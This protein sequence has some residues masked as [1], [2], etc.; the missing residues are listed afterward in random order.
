MAP[1]KLADNCSGYRFTYI[2]SASA[3]SINLLV[4]KT[5]KAS[6]GHINATALLS[7]RTPAHMHARS[8]AHTR[9]YS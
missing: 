4:V 3:I 6:F 2:A 1:I 7:N 8:R 9:A 5:L